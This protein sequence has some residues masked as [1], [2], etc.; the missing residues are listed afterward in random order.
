MGWIGSS[1]MK[2]FCKARKAIGKAFVKFKKPYERLFKVRT[3]IEECF[4]GIGL[5]YNQVFIV[6]CANN[7]AVDRME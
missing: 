5:F 2:S 1:Y 6:F 4:C 7:V 3:A